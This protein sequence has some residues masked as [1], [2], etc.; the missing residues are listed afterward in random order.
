MEKIYNFDSISKI[1]KVSEV[2]MSY[3]CSIDEM[4]QSIVKLTEQMK[5]LSSV[6]AR[7]DEVEKQ[8]SKLR[9]ALDDTPEIPNQKCDL[10]ILNQIVPSE[11]FLKLENNIS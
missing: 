10:E 8:V 7:V 4:A 6:N 11:A 1:G 3:G 5:T 9:S 2:M